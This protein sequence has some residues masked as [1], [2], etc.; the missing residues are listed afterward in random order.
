[1]KREGRKIPDVI[2]GVTRS[3]TKGK[4]RA[5]PF[6]E[7]FSAEADL[8]PRKIQSWVPD[9]EETSGS[10]EQPWE[11]SQAY[12][13]PIAAYQQSQ[14]FQQGRIPFQQQNKGNVFQQK[15]SGAPNGFSL[16]NALAGQNKSPFAPSAFQQK[17]PAF[18][19]VQQGGPQQP[20]SAFQQAMSSFP[21]P[22]VPAFPQPSSNASVFNPAAPAFKPSVPAFQQV[23]PAFAKPTT[24]PF[25]QTA[26]AFS[27][28]TNASAVSLGSGF[29][30]KFGQSSA[31]ASQSTA[32]QSPAPQSTAPHKPPADSHLVNKAP[33]PTPAFTPPKQQLHTP[34]Q[35]FV[36]YGSGDQ[37]GTAWQQEGG[38][39]QEGYYQGEGGEEG[40][41]EEHAGG[42]GDED[43]EYALRQADIV[44]RQGEVAQMKAQVDAQLEETKRMLAEKEAAAQ[45]RKKDKKQ[46]E[47]LLNHNFAQQGIQ[48]Q[49][50]SIFDLPPQQPPTA[51]PLFSFSKPAEE[52]S[53][54]N[55]GA[56]GPP[57]GASSVFFQNFKI[58]QSPLSPGL[59]NR[60]SFDREKA[61]GAGQRSNAPGP[62]PNIISAPEPKPERELSPEPSP[63][64]QDPAV[65]L[66]QFSLYG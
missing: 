52:P 20:P 40:Y 5:G 60:I 29:S 34:N 1:M 53:P 57:K 10:H 37:S 41:Y 22:P 47:C 23:A 30:A 15:Q 55:V 51:T 50:K 17:T 9:E 13:D 18:A 3:I 45:Q 7:D 27:G 54:P 25:S 46:A 14:G 59:E 31:S 6:E 28:G 8:G 61:A 64:H 24:G 58:P 38:W 56:F 21:T 2:N 12:A 49:Q 16:Q 44:R 11:D 35:G 39:D 19:R 42:D 43:D 4:A 26:P 63:P 36:Y 65:L 66:E 48:Q 33:S 32:P 62:E